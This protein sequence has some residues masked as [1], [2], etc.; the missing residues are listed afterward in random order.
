MKIQSPQEIVK[1]LLDT[2]KTP[3]LAMKSLAYTIRKLE[4]AKT[5]LEPQ[6]ELTNMKWAYLDLKSRN[7]GRE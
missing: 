6:P 3:S 2:F 7:F 1:E 4:E 5:L